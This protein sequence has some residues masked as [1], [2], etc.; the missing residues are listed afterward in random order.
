[1]Q[2]Y[3]DPRRA[4]DKWSL[5]DVEIFQLTAEEVAESSMFED[6]RHEYMKMHEFRLASMNGRVRE[7]MIATMIEDLCIK[8]G[9]FWWTCFPGCMPDGDPIGPFATEAEA[10]A[11][12]QGDNTETDAP[13]DP[14]GC[15]R[16]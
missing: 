16:D 13:G 14:E 3:S 9:W 11:D 4:N 6:E 15:D 12:A 7:K 5:P 2:A 10:L 8:G 1:M